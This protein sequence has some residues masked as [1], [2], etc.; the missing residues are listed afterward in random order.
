MKKKR[1][2]FDRSRDGNVSVQLV[3]FN[4]IWFIRCVKPQIYTHV[5]GF[6]V[7]A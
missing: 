1:I 2:I 4:G 6:S 5:S 7:E 3:I